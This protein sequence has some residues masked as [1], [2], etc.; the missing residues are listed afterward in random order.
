MEKKD[1]K[2]TLHLLHIPVHLLHVHLLQ[3]GVVFLHILSWSC[4][5]TFYMSVHPYLQGSSAETFPVVCLHCQLAVYCDSQP[6]GRSDWS[7]FFFIFP[8]LHSWVFGVDSTIAATL[9]SCVARLL[10]QISFLQCGSE[11]EQV[12][13][14]NHL[15]IL[16][17]FSK[18]K[19]SLSH[20]T[21]ES[22]VS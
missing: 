3:V 10:R 8:L 5:C 13:L 16:E 7:N 19:W 14:S 17:F 22:N 1:K 12:R 9:H 21:V 4:F 6:T 2:S 20:S 11:V 18:R 15:Q